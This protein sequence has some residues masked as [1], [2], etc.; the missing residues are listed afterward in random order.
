LRPFKR[1]LLGPF[2]LSLAAFKEGYMSGCHVQLVSFDEAGFQPLGLASPAA[3]LRAAGFTV[4]TIDVGVDKGR[5]FGE[6]DVICFSIPIFAAIGPA[7]DAADG[8]RNRGVRGPFIF[9]NQYA[10]V[11]PESF[12]LDE[13]CHVVLGEF[14][15]V[16][17]SVADAVSAKKAL[18]G[19]PHLWSSE[20][21]KP[22]KALRRQQF[23]MPDRSTLPGL[24][25]YAKRDDGKLIGNI[26][27]M[28][29]CAHPCSYCSVFAAYERRVVKYDEQIVLEDIEQVVRHGAEHITFVDADFFS[30]GRRGH[31][32]LEAMAERFP[33]L[34]FDVTVRLD[35]IIRYKDLLPDLKKFGCVELT[36]A[37]EFPTDKVLQA[38]N[39]GM[40]LRQMRDAVALVQEVGIEVKPTFI[41]HNPWVSQEESAALDVFIGETGLRIDN[42]QRATRLLLY[43]GSPL[44]A[45]PEIQKL[46]LVDKRT[47]Y[48]WAHPDPKMDARYQSLAKELGTAMPQRCCIK[49]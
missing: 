5:S 1:L 31:R 7:I 45:S 9:Y 34:P 20:P 29:G 3:Y 39:K 32:I 36:T 24:S 28:R 38:V 30:T 41:T 13:D 49:G 2:L 37:C 26:E 44:L 27:S 47:Y 25:H 42:M 18:K 46:N 14:E 33:G 16:L 11:Q 40:T 22:A 21:Q 4:D 10:T 17:V 19:R 48:E 6:G 15:E 12:R 43:K 35:D 8:L 23:L